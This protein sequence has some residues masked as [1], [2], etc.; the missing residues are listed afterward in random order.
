MGDEVNGTIGYKA[1]LK[2]TV[3][4]VRTVGFKCPERKM[5]LPFWRN[6]KRLSSRQLAQEMVSRG[7]AMCELGEL[8]VT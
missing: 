1:E 2:Y 4:E 7:R 6:P 8:S 5:Y 3:E